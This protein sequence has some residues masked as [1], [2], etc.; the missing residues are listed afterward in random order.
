LFE[1]SFGIG[2]APQEL[3]FHCGLFI[4]LLPRF[5]QDLLTARLHRRHKPELHRKE[6]ELMADQSCPI[7]SSALLQLEL[8][9]LQPEHKVSDYQAAM[10]LAREQATQ[11]F[12]EYMLVSWYDRDRDFE[13]P[14]HSSECS[15]GGRKDGYVHYG[16]SHG[17]KL[18]VDIE[19]GRF[20][21]FFTPVEW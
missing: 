13:W 1:R 15:D 19:D 2:F 16:L 21:F 8:V 14:P 3:L 18:K 17:A 5:L 9:S 4:S 6:D 11:R 10:A 7:N 20:V 12:E